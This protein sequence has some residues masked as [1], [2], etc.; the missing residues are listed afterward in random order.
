M[1]DIDL[2]AEEQAV[3]LIRG[4]LPPKGM[5]SIAAE[6]TKPKEALALHD[7]LQL[8]VD[9]LHDERQQR[10]ESEGAYRVWKRRTEAAEEELSAEKARTEEIRAVVQERSQEIGD[11]HSETQA[12]LVA[13]KRDLKD[14]YATNTKL[15][16]RLRSALNYRE[17]QEGLPKGTLTD[18]LGSEKEGT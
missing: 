17:S 1:N 6:P 2:G 13:A 4:F 14:A 8:L 12:E 3:E 10:L 7:A 11:A 9:T 16:M 15:S 5:K 18:G